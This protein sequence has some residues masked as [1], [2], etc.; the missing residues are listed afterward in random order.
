MAELSSDEKWAFFKTKF[1][2]LS[3]L[4]LVVMLIGVMIWADIH[5]SD[6]FLT[7][8]FQTTTTVL[9]TYLGLAQPWKKQVINGGTNGS[10]ST[11]STS[12]STSGTTS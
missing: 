2:S 6:K 12:T 11:T 7:W 4:S 5:S 10:T 1:D 9:G 3:C 8:L